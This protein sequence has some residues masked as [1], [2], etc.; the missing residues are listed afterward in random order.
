MK[1]TEL[2]SAELRKYAISALGNI[3]EHAVGS[4]FWKLKKASCRHITPEELKKKL[5][6]VNC[7]GE[8]EYE[9]GIENF[10]ARG[11]SSHEAIFRVIVFKAFGLNI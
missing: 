8:G 5:P 10:L 1:I 7:V 2:D 11:K 3:P 9:A 4:I 6:A